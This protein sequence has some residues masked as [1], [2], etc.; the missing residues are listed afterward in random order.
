MTRRAMCVMTLSLVFC[1]VSLSARAEEQAAPAAIAAKIPT[2]APL[3][4]AEGTINELNLAAATPSLK[5][6]DANG[7][8]W[9]IDM[10]KTTSV[11]QHGQIE[12]PSALKVGDRVQVSFT[13]DGDRHVAK[14]IQTVEATKPV[15][16]SPAPTTQSN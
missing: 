7:Q 12:T 8:S 11:L 15:A 5:L 6:S 13:S 2:A 1:G 3:T 4:T 16:S 9:T 10:D 14:F